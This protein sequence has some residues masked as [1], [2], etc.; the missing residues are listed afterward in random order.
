MEKHHKSTFVED[1]LRIV[2][3]I[4]FSI[5]RATSFPQFVDN[6]PAVLSN[7]Q[8]KTLTECP[9]PFQCVDLCRCRKDDIL[10]SDDPL[11]VIIIKSELPNNDSALVAEFIDDCFKVS[12]EL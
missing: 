6:Q 4:Q 2:F 1:F 3:L 10:Q 5:S 9:P 7:Q 12:Y 11:S 8:P